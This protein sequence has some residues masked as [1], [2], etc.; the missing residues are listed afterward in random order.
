MKFL[1]NTTP[2]ENGC[3]L[4]TISYALSQTNL[5]AGKC[6]S[7]H[8][9][10]I[11][12]LLT[13]FASVYRIPNISRKAI[14]RLFQFYQH[15]EDQQKLWIGPLRYILGEV[16]RHD[17]QYCDNIFHTFVAALEHYVMADNQTIPN[18]YANIFHANQAFFSLARDSYW[19]VRST[20]RQ[21]KAREIFQTIKLQEYWQRIG[22]ER[23][24]QQLKQVI[25][26]PLMLTAEEM[27]IL[28][29]A[30]QL[31]FN[32]YQKD[33]ES[34]PTFKPIVHTCKGYEGDKPFATVSAICTQ[35]HWQPIV[36]SLSHAFR[37]QL[38]WKQGYRQLAQHSYP[39]I[40]QAAKKIL[41]TEV[42]KFKA[43][44]LQKAMILG[45]YQDIAKM[46]Q[47]QA[48]KAD[49]DNGF[50]ANID[51]AVKVKDY[52]T[53][54]S[55]YYYKPNSRNYILSKALLIYGTGFVTE[56]LKYYSLLPNNIEDTKQWAAALEKAIPC[57][58]QT[59]C[60]HDLH[61]AVRRG[62]DVNAKKLIAD[63][64]DIYFENDSKVSPLHLVCATE[65]QPI[66][67]AMIE[68]E[69]LNQQQGTLWQ[70]FRYFGLDIYRPDVSGKTPLHYAAAVSDEHFVARI[71]KLRSNPLNIIEYV[72]LNITD[73]DGK[74]P[75]H[76]A[77][78]NA[79]GAVL[80]HFLNHFHLAKGGL[81]TQ[82][83]VG[84]TPL[85]YAVVTRRY[86]NIPLLLQ[87]K[88]DPSISAYPDKIIT[89]FP[90]FNHQLTQLTPL[91]L[92]LELEDLMSIKALISNVSQ[93][94]NPVNSNGHNALQ[95]AVLQERTELLTHWDRLYPNNHLLTGYKLLHFAAM[96]GKLNV[97]EFFVAKGAV[98][99]SVDSDCNSALHYAAQYGRQ[100]V[101]EYICDMAERDHRHNQLVAMR[102][103]VHEF[104]HRRR[105]LIKI[106]AENAYGETPY[107]LAHIY[108]YT[109]VARRLQRE[110]AKSIS[111]AEHAIRTIYRADPQGLQSDENKVA[112]IASK[113]HRIAF[114]SD[115]QGD[116]LIHHAIKRLN[117]RVLRTLLHS[118]SVADRRAICLKENRQGLTPLTLIT[119]LRQRG[120]LQNV[121]KGNKSAVY[122]R[123][124]KA[125]IEVLDVIERALICYHQPTYERKYATALQRTRY[126]RACSQDLQQEILRSTGYYY[127]SWATM[128]GYPAYQAVK[129][130][131]IATHPYILFETAAAAFLGNDLIANAELGTSLLL[132]HYPDSKL[133]Q[134]TSWAL[135]G[136]GWYCH[137]GRKLGMEISK[138][139]S[140]LALSELSLDQ[141]SIASKN[142]VTYLNYLGGLYA[143]LEFLG[144]QT[145]GDFLE[146][147]V[148]S[149]DQGI[150]Q[151]TGSRTANQVV[152]DAISDLN[153]T[154]REAT[155]LDVANTAHNSYGWFRENVIRLPSSGT[156]LLENLDTWVLEPLNLSDE[157]QKESLKQLLTSVIEQHR[158]DGVKI[159]QL[160]ESLTQY[161]ATG[162]VNEHLLTHLTAV[163]QSVSHHD[164]GDQIAQFTLMAPFYQSEHFTAEHR[165]AL[166]SQ[167]AQEANQAQNAN[168][169]S[170]QLASSLGDVLSRASSAGVAMLSQQTLAAQLLQQQV[171]DSYVQTLKPG[172]EIANDYKNILSR[173]HNKKSADGLAEYMAQILVFNNPVF[174]CDLT[175]AQK[176]ALQ[177][178]FRAF[179]NQ[180]QGGNDKYN[181]GAV[182][183]NFDRIKTFIICAPYIESIING[184]QVTEAV[185]AIFAQL[186]S[187]EVRAAMAAH[188]VAAMISEAEGYT[189]LTVTQ[190][191]EL[192]R[193]FFDQQFAS[194]ADKIERGIRDIVNETL[195]RQ[196]INPQQLTL[197]WGEY[198][199][200][201]AANYV[202]QTSRNIAENR[203]QG[204]ADVNIR[205]LEYK[206]QSGLSRF[207]HSIE[208]EARKAFKSGAQESAVG[209]TVS[210]TQML[211]TY[212]H[213]PSGT[214][215]G[216]QN[217]F[218]K[219]PLTFTMPSS[220][221][222]PTQH[223]TPTS[224]APS[225]VA[226]QSD[227]RT[228]TFATALVEDRTPTFTPL[229]AA[230]DVR[231]GNVAVPC[232]Q[233]ESGFWRQVGSTLMNP[234]PSQDSHLLAT[235]QASTKDSHSLAASSTNNQALVNEFL[236]HSWGQ[237]H[238]EPLHPKLPK[239]LMNLGSTSQ[240]NV[241]LPVVVP[242][243]SF[244]D[245][246][247]DLVIGRA[248]A[249]PVVVAGA[250]IAGGAAA[251]VGAALVQ[252][253]L[254]AWD[255]QRENDIVS[256]ALNIGANLYTTSYPLMGG[257]GLF[258]K[259]GRNDKPRPNAP[260]PDKRYVPAP[261]ELPGF[262]EA[263]RDIPKTPYPGGLRKRWELPDGKIL[264]WDAQHGEVE[265]YTKKGD[266]LGAYDPVTGE[267]IK[268]PN[269]NRTIKK[270]L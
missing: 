191:F 52:S 220:V 145:V 195:T 2:W 82:D 206:K 258:R 11:E 205:V 50:F 67:M 92:A 172:Q 261:K 16:L 85:H 104:F 109:A 157:T 270:F 120:M 78:M 93:L 209:V 129:T 197:L 269:K 54:L 69:R 121:P 39:A 155:S 86:D 53:L 265:L 232:W 44:K 114:A 178:Y 25:G 59:F 35:Q 173:C 259:S 136:L 216:L 111:L 71:L 62:D 95:L 229:L 108:G 134:G 17:Q 187:K 5:L 208:R 124:S 239:S 91:W 21:A 76:I 190:T 161:V 64:E 267:Q 169:T 182:V 18:E 217:P 34:Q 96:V 55:I 113:H 40:V 73:N 4:A 168:L 200:D 7:F 68:K 243:P 24:C 247:L 248:N 80:K 167:I 253:T 154:I 97:I 142:Y 128:L 143:G 77:A 1:L 264:E 254:A 42:K 166:R 210:G 118:L 240:Q 116:T 8:D 236:A 56:L 226:V 110:G 58:A 22:Y 100:A 107:A 26:V 244:G 160:T 37:H 112:N 150:A 218:A 256:Q 151:A 46:C 47:E 98:L 170:S 19:R 233:S 194:S 87:A 222:T 101:V 123:L 262:P 196:A 235:T 260:D 231:V 228:P 125:Q 251:G 164:F 162:Q 207:T 214:V 79:N 225:S 174:F 74:T 213:L 255:P 33:S 189:A 135:W 88:A 165:E 156:T 193:S 250:V 14:L 138:A 43:P 126:H 211:P 51:I 29:A 144:K 263:E 186:D 61:L 41:L 60:D 266:H 75:L 175:S 227:D 12:K 20:R 70:R 122:Q 81:N 163:A 139:A 103:G 159:L 201:A 237:A 83:H 94:L 28:C 257:V 130:V 45:H 198:T 141:T 23:Y 3:G 249:N 180:I 202:A 176:K 185:P 221:S 153:T 181:E 184:T 48:D 31:R 117:V 219:T 223:R 148:V 230:N 105:H 27:S 9:R 252:S 192:F 140:S 38:L 127:A 115:A 177:D 183:K 49:P 57:I 215:V 179:F 234:L 147:H 188:Q 15:P 66:L 119:D 212:S 13:A 171:I 36:D 203:W 133:L 241:L 224:V 65:N 204:T 6:P 106:D 30:L 199:A 32:I 268:K 137:T 132:T 89:V 245:R 72:K 152:N 102:G 10:A 242:E 246:L 90:Q 149:F 158:Y 99:S 146:K 84:L 238:N 131:G 63:G